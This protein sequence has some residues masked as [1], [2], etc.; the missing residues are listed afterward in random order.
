MVG[1]FKLKQSTR[2][3]GKLDEISP[4]VLRMLEEMSEKKKSNAN[5]KEEA[6]S[7]AASTKSRIVLSDKEFGKY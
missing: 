7:E 1:E 3:H 5:P 6:R 4:E 2:S